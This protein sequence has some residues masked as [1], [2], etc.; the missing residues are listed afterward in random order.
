MFFVFL[1]NTTVSDQL[2]ELL[3]LGTNPNTQLADGNTCLHISTA[4][5]YVE[6]VAVMN[7]NIMFHFY[8]DVFDISFNLVLIHT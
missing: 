4:N 6:S 5:G 2:V 3:K 8:L 7:E 1:T